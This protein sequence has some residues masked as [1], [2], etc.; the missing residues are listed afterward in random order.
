MKVILRPPHLPR[1][2]RIVTVV[3][4]KRDEEDVSKAQ[5]QINAYMSRINEISSPDNSFKGFLVLED[6]V[7]IY[8][9]VGYGAYRYPEKVGMYSMFDAGNP[10]TRD[11]ADIAIRYW[12]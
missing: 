8:S 11:L 2:Y 6:V 3:E 5:S 7:E 4:L 9:Y 10:W 1:D 12:N